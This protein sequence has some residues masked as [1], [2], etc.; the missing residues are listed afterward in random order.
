MSR[1]PRLCLGIAW[2]LL[3]LGLAVF[4]SSSAWAA[5]AAV[6]ELTPYRVRLVLSVEPAPE[7]TAALEAELRAGLAQQAELW[8]GNAWNVTV[9]TAP[10]ALRDRML[11][12]L[13][14]IAPEA[15]PAE[16]LTA[17]KVTLLVLRLTLDGYE[18]C[19]RELDVRTRVWG[20][21]V[22]ATAGHTAQLTDT[23]FSV[24][25]RAFA[26][27]AQVEP[28]EKSRDTVQLRLRAAGLPIRDPSCL[29]TAPGALFRPLVRTNDREGNLRQITPLP[30][31]YFV[32]SEV[33]P[34]LLK[35]QVFSGVRSPMS[36][37]PR[38]RIEQ[39]ALAIHPS[40]G[41]TRVLVRS[42]TDKNK[43]LVGYQMYR[44][45]PD[46]KSVTY[47]GRTDR[48]GSFLVE[49]SEEPLR[50]LLIKSGEE[51]LARLPVV[52]GFEAE[53]IAPVADD[54]QRLEAEGFITGFQENLV[55][56]VTRREVMQAQIRAR[57]QAKEFPQARER[58]QEFRQMKG[59][60]ELTGDLKREQQK[61]FSRDPAIQRKIDKLFEDTQKL[62]NQYLGPGAVER[63]ARELSD[64]QSGKLS[65][66]SEDAAPAKATG[67]KG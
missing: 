25:R 31:T 54:D 27:L 63:L 38:G 33:T 50:M 45:Q 41:A 21:A 3:A 32:V 58:L 49:P 10:P 2:R 36:A 29:T 55:D 66:E 16:W 51:L 52:P 59:R 30:W 20:T 5:S 39:L 60:D 40:G 37:R 44:Q 42:R 46:T 11:T 56:L 34:P 8:I 62:L 47:L 57:I 6:W 15:L 18:I 26:P 4:G 22:T 14:A 53:T 17:D 64:A 48:R 24:V 35:C 28:I 43:P 61:I 9:E 19:G 12:D 23:L 7:L 67:E 13:T 65:A 1:Q